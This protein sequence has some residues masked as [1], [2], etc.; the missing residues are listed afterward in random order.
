MIKRTGSV[1]SDRPFL[2]RRL[3]GVWV[4]VMKDNSVNQRRGGNGTGRGNH[5][6]SC[7]V[8]GYDLSRFFSD[9]IATV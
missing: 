4:C 5:D 2:S 9:S 6:V 1:D 3:G 8:D 7:R